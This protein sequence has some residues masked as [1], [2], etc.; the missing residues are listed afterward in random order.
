MRQFFYFLKDKSQSKENTELLKTNSICLYWHASRTR[1]GAMQTLFTVSFR[2]SRNLAQCNQT[3]E[4][5]YGAMKV[6]NYGNSELLVQFPTK[7][8]I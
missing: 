3:F 8:V 6:I 2:L 1:I 7:K 5:G 4:P